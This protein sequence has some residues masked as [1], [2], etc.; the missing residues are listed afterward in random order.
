[1]ESDPTDR[2]AGRGEIDVSG[3]VRPA[4]ALEG[5]QMSRDTAVLG[6]VISLVTGGHLQYLSN[7][8]WWSELLVMVT[9]VLLTLIRQTH[10]WSGILFYPTHLP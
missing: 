3:R 10:I 2:V 6:F 5:S 9:V 7:T 4:G 8:L 1:M